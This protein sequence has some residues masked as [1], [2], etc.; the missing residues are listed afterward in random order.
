VSSDARR[1]ARRWRPRY[2]RLMAAPPAVPVVRTL[3]DLKGLAALDVVLVVGYASAIPAY[4]AAALL[5][6][7]PV[8]PAATEPRRAR[9]RS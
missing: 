6:P 9:G 7:E 3:E 8:P 2:D 4:L 5:K 1:L